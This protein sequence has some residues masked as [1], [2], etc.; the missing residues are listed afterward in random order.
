MASPLILRPYFDGARYQPLALL[1]PGWESRVSV[2]VALDSTHLGP[3]WPEDSRDR[4]RLADLVPPMQGRGTDALT[5]F[6][7]Y[8]EHPAPTGGGQG[9][10]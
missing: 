5:A 6:L 10:R 8:F 1:L 4:E 3:A 9:G 7:H 2:P